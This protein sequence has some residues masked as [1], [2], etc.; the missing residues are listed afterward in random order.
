ILYREKFHA[1][2]L[3]KNTELIALVDKGF[4]AIS[5][6]ELAEIEAHWIPDPAKRYYKASKIIGLTP[7]EETWLR[8]HKTIRVGMSPVLPPLKFSEK[9]VIKGIEPDYLNLLSEYTGIQFEYVICNF[10]VMDAKVKSGEMDMFLSFNIPERLAYMTFTEPLMEFKQVFIARSDA[11]FMSGIGALKGKKIATVK[12]VKLYEKL[13]S[14]YPEIEVV[15]VA[16]TEEMFRAVSESK[17]DALISRTYIAGYVMQNYPNLKMAGVADL[18]PEPFTYAVRKDY[19]ELIN[20]LNKAIASIP[21]D[22]QDAI[23]QKWFSVQVEYRPNWSEILKWAFAI[24]GVF[25]LILGLSLFWNRRLA[26]EI[27]ER[28]QTEEALRESER[29]LNTTGKMAKIGGWEFDVE[30]LEQIW[31]EEVYRIHEVDLDYKPTVEKGIDFYAPESRPII[32]QAV[33]RAID[34]GEPFDVELRF[35]T[36]KGNH[37][38]VHALGQA[39]KKNGKTT[40][41]WG[42]FQDITEKKL[43]EEALRESEKRFRSVFES[44]MIGTL[45]WNADGDIIDANNS[46]LQMLGYTKDELLSGEVRWRDM[47]PPEYKEQDDRALQEITARGVISPIEKEYIRKDGSR[48]PILLGGASLPGSTLGGVAFILDITERKRAEEALR[49]EK[50]FSESLIDTAQVIILLL[51]AEGRIVRFNP[52][53]EDLCGYR[54]D[55]VQG[56]D[57]FSTFLPE[58]DYDQVREVFRAAVSDIQTWGN[59]N[60]I[61]AKDGREIIV[62][63]YDKTLKDADGNTIGL[64][65][66]GQDIT[67]RNRAEEQVRESEERHRTILQTAMDGFWLVDL[68]G[69]LM[70]VNETYCQMSGYSEPE[71]LA[72]HIL[73]LEASET[74]DQIAA[75]IQKTMAQGEER[76][77]TRH[78]RKD[79]SIF[80]VEISIQYRPTEGG[81]FVAFLRNI[82]ERK[83]AEEALQQ[84]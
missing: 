46:F 19:P 41:I 11:P 24:G 58:Q 82:T 31:T 27:D 65:A 21:R 40:K 25:I 81:W 20:I 32:E 78:R 44:K 45:F 64:L 60:P 37:L 28:R 79:G 7:A 18:P 49:K 50:D 2:V 53:M 48:I 30:T 36:A 35:I 70:Q 42:V 5:H 66:I 38:W 4:N 29:I 76:F 68:D 67:E 75:H 55:E 33:Q 62:E 10:S 56:K 84:E 34:D 17:A 80:D 57:W 12:G 71:L 22:K 13:L 63:W 72:M 43:A 1:G 51:D 52:Y 23:A 26:R 15:Q 61:V 8:N 77:E 59:I 9:G 69:R 73:D 6:K 16:N 47:T 83:Q 54:L 74:P 14:P 39:H 3:E